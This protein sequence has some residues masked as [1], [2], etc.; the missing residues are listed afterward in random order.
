MY[1]GQTVRITRKL[2][3]QVDKIARRLPALVSLSQTPTSDLFPQV[4][5]QVN[6]YQI[7]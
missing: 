6:A 4:A 3:E 7:Q 5:K 1:G 2:S